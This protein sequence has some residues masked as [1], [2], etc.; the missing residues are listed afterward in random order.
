M[1]AFAV[2]LAVLLT[3]NTAA[4]EPLPIVTEL[5]AA[6]IR[7][8]D[9]SDMTSADNSPLSVGPPPLPLTEL[10]DQSVNRWVAELAQQPDF[11]DWKTARWERQ[12]LGPGLHGWI[13]LVSDGKRELGYLVVIMDPDGEYRLAEYGLGQYP[14]FSENT[15]Y[16]S[17]VQHGLISS[18]I[19][20]EQFATDKR[21]ARDR[22]YFS[23]LQ[24]VWSV[25]LEGSDYVLDAKTGELLIL[26][27]ET[28]NALSEISNKHHPWPAPL[29]DTLIIDA[30][31]RLPPFDPYYDLSWVRNK[32]VKIKDLQQLQIFLQ[33]KTKLTFVTDL[34]NGEIVYAF[35]VTGYHQWSGG[36]PF[37][38]LDQDGSRFIPAEYMLQ[39][40]RFFHSR[41]DRRIRYKSAQ[42]P[43]PIE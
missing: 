24:N 23:P 34:Y 21:S 26:N 14:L 2:I 35:S 27:R 1:I 43:S 19:T 25:T 11:S 42:I 8:A 30:A 29:G 18:S 28:L 36:D 13:V 4:A 37:L 31:L 7:A 40:G 10:F 6:A 39:T 16:R 33:N 17:L 9:A 5:A 41:G 15:L 12:P 3:S 32:P 38:S 20:F 22:W